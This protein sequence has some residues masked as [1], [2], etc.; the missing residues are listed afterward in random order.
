MDISALEAFSLV[1]KQRS[2]ARAARELNIDPSSISRTISALEDELD[3]RLFQRDTRK[4]TLTE[5]GT[6]YHQRVEPLV[7]ELHQAR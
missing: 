1:V 5:A 6:I 4:L 2:F 3:M 7:D